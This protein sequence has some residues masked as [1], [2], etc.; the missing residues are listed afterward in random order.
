MQPP[1]PLPCAPQIARGCIRVEK[2]THLGDG[3]VVIS[4]FGPPAVF[5][6]FF[7][8]MGSRV[9]SL[10][11]FICDVDG[12]ELYVIKPSSLAPYIAS[13]SLM[14]VCLYKYLAASMARKYRVLAA[15]AGFGL[16]RAGEG[17]VQVPLSEIL[18]NSVFRSFYS[19]YVRYE[20]REKAAWL[21][22]WQGVEDF[23]VIPRGA[24]ANAAAL[25]LDERYLRAGADDEV[26]ASPAV[27]AAI[28]LALG[29]Q[30]EGGKQLVPSNTFDVAQQ[31]RRDH[32][33][34]ASKSRRD[35]AEIPDAGG[36]RGAARAHVR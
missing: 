28:K 31:E 13:K 8:L 11:S 21:A 9:P 27:R 10:T 15:T 22:F 26:P 17:A 16:T 25:A 2:T 7:F 29:K 23:R 34:I 24:E 1:P 19:R 18:A 3:T 5:G 14:P 32:V 33:E 30:V 4:R 35:H 36:L 20:R 12:T 6:E